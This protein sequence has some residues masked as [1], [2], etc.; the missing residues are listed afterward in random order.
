MTELPSCETGGE[1]EPFH[2]KETAEDAQL[3]I[4]V[5]NLNY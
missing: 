3:W 4:P 2:N 1:K 5:R